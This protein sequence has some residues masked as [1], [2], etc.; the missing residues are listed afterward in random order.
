MVLELKAAVV[1]ALFQEYDLAVSTIESPNYDY[2]L[3]DGSDGQK[4]CELLYV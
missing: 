4:C 1:F 3:V 2:F